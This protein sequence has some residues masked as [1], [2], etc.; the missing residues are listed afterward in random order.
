MFKTFWGFTSEEAGTVLMARQMVISLM[1]SAAS[2]NN[3]NPCSNTYRGSSPESE[4]ETKAVTDFIRSHLKSI[5]AYITFHSYS[6]MLLFPYGYTKKWPPNHKDLVCR[7]KSVN[8]TLT[9]PFFFSLFF[10][11]I[12][13]YFNTKGLIKFYLEY[14]S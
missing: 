11:I 7:K 4:K 13:L 1:S 9:S 3:D 5:K 10:V 8:Y 2:L 12:I 6:Q 14:K